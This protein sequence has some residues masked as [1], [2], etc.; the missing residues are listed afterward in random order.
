MEAMVNKQLSSHKKKRIHSREMEEIARLAT[1]EALK[2][3]VWPLTP[4]DEKNLTLGMFIDH[5]DK[6]HKT[7]E[8]YISADPPENGI[9]LTQAKVNA[10]TGEV[11]V[12]VFLPRR[13][14]AP[15]LSDP[16]VQQLEPGD[17]SKTWLSE[18]GDK[19]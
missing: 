4:E 16:S 17:E 14:D 7:F 15:P 6:D 2:E 11:Q 1:R 5:P 13:P 8:L 9:V 12:K 10:L 19:P 18:R 3:Y